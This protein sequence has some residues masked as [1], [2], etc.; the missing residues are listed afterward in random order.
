MSLARKAV[1]GAAWTVGTSVGARAIGL[2]GTLA[3]T[4]FLSPGDVGEVSAATILVLTA[5]Q[6]STPGL[7]QYLI[8]QPG[9]PRSVAFHVTFFHLLLGLVALGV[10]VALR[11][12][13]A[14][15]LDAPGLVHFVPGMALSVFIERLAYTPEKILI[16]DMRFRTIGLGRTAG[17]LTYTATS[18]ALAA[19][20]WGGMSIVA[21][22]LLRSA[23]L[24]A[25]FLSA[26]DRG[27]WLS[28]SP[29]SRATTRALFGYGIPLSIG[30][31]AEFAARRWDNLLVARFFGTSTMGAYNLAYNLA[32]VPASHV[33]EHIGEVLTPSFANMTAEQSRAALLRSTGLLGLIV[34][35]LSIGLGVVAPTLV[36]TIFD[37]RWAAVGP[38]LLL[39]SVLSVSRP[40]GWTIAAYQQA[41]MQPRA[42]MWLGLFKVVALM[43]SIVVIGRSSPL[44]TCAAVGIGFAV[45]AVAG[46]LIVRRTDGVSVLAF[47]GR[48]APALVA[49]VPMALAVLALRP[50]VAGLP[51][52]LPLACEIAVGAAV[53]PFSALFIAGPTTRDFIALV[54]QGLLGR[55]GAG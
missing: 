38:M 47:I 23:V 48:I 12:P 42:A 25:V 40:I 55:Q 34:F 3:L 37:Q 50:L 24:C 8:A 15:L 35:P 52:P 46:L 4:H 28:V 29:L 10:V 19:L 54:R 1:H 14:P 36:G 2:F 49:C 27:Q 20:G 51:R 18:L 31:T 33:G 26:I 32:D 16:R 6:L 7:G 17:E 45:Y 44:W 22:N 13:L 11:H 39:L 30:A 41:R 43:T 53:F 9:A 21:G 5:G